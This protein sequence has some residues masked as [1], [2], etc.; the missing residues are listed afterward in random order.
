M[1]EIPKI[2]SF[3]FVDGKKLKVVAHRR[4]VRNEILI[5]WAGPGDLVGCCLPSYWYEKDKRDRRAGS[6]APS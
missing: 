5:E 2:G 4:N 1:R 6:G 3:Q